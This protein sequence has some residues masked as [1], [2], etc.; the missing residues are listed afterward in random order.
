MTTTPRTRRAAALLASTL[1]AGGLLVACGDDG[2]ATETGGDDTT[3][4]AAA[5]GIEVSG[6][7]A[8]TSP[9]VVDA[10]AA[11]MEL[12]NG[13]DVDDALVSASVDASV[14][15]RTELHETRAAGGDM[16]GTE[17]TT[18]EMGGEGSTTT[19]MMEMVPVD[20]IEVPAGETVAL[21]PG[22]LHV[23]LLELVEPLAAGDL[24]RITLTFEVA[25]EVVVDAVVGDA[26]PGA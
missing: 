5:A 4:E 7:W 15:A 21:E 2:D 20:R 8:R 3:T 24:V 14:A 18:G 19:P 1:L 13:G 10:A 26:A 22:G 12:T 25:G 17:T 23:M 9:M 6:A 16:G 11:Y